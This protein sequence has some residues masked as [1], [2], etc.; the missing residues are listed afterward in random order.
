VLQVLAISI[1]VVLRC[2]C[3]ISETARNAPRSK[4][5]PFISITLRSYLIS[6]DLHLPW[7]FLTTLLRLLMHKQGTRRCRCC[8]ARRCQWG[9]TVHFGRCV[10]GFHVLCSCMMKTQCIGNLTRHAKLCGHAQYSDFSGE[11]PPDPH[12]SSYFPEIQRSGHQVSGAGN[13]SA[14]SENLRSALRDGN[15]SCGASTASGASSTRDTTK[16]YVIL[17]VVVSGCGDFL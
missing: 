3:R 14:A 7:S 13:Q 9:S 2:W 1:P 6:V 10:T 12:P 11:E 15:A 17:P 16:E 8:L 5:L 4:K